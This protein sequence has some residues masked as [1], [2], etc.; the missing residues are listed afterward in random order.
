VILHFA[1]PFLL[2]LSRD[3]KRNAR[4]LAL[5]A[6]VVF[7][8]RF[9]DLFWIITPTFRREHFGLSFMDIVA[10]LAV[11]GLWVSFFA[12]QL[13]KR[14]LLPVNDPYLEQALEHANHH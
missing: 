1:L 13:K 4:K 5:L 2:L 12:W 14:P 8:M 7:V 10:P 3:L 9:V 6:M 11:G